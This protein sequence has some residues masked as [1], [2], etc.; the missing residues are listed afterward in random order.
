MNILDIRENIRYNNSIDNVINQRRTEHE[1][2]IKE[3]EDQKIFI[4]PTDL[5][6]VGVC[7]WYKNKYPDSNLTDD[8]IIKRYNELEEKYG[9]EL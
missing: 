4:D 9:D 7:D 6:K 5:A 1:K 2:S 3:L 8:E